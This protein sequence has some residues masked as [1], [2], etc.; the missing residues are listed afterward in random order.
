MKR[1]IIDHH[2]HTGSHFPHFYLNFISNGTFHIII[3]YLAHQMKLLEFMW[4]L[5]DLCEIWIEFSPRVIRKLC[6]AGELWPLGIFKLINNKMCP[7]CFR[8]TVRLTA[9]IIFNTTFN[10]VTIRMCAFYC[11]LQQ[12]LCELLQYDITGKYGQCQLIGM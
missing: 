2:V 6:L 11:L 1:Y 12:D 7:Y 5:W 3:S 10:E 9:T 4:L 8:N